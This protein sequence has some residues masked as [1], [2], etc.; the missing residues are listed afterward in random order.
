MIEAPDPIRVLICDDSAFMR[1]ALRRLIE[2]DPGIKV[3]AQAA[4][5]TEALQLIAQHDPD[6]VTLDIEMPGMSGLDVLRRIMEEKPRHVI[7]ISSLTQEGAEITLQALGEGAF[8][9]IAKSLSHVSLDIVKIREELVAKIHAA[10]HS[11]R[12]SRV[13]AKKPSQPQQLQH[14]ACTIVPRVVVLGTSTGGPK[15]LQ[16][17]LPMLPAD[18]PVPVI[19]VQ[20]MPVGF[21]GPFARRLD[22][23]CRIHI[24]EATPDEILEPGHVYIG[25]ASWQ[26]TPYQKS[27][28]RYALRLSKEPGNTPHIP[29]VDIMMLAAAKVYGRYAMGVVLTGMGNDGEAGMRA[30]HQAGSYTITQDEATSTVW[31]M[32][33]ACHEAGIAT[34]TVPLQ[35]VPSEIMSAVRYSP[36]PAIG[37]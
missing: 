1:T 15:A 19:I 28:S 12:P 2:S 10:A 27:P 5:G 7:M 16:E 20:H 9:C 22:N 37:R 14:A 35:Q 32:P 26:I 36:K 18:L 25:P 30:L 17:I 29:S 6:V 33:R 3:V 13:A 21:T 11:P 8:D 34:H 31:G 23:L 4:N 24:T